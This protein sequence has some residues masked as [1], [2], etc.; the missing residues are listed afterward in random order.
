MRGACHVAVLYAVK[1][2]NTAGRACLKTLVGLKPDKARPRAVTY[3]VRLKPDKARPR[4][5]TCE[6]RLKPDKARPRAI[7]FEVRLKP[8]N[9]RP[10]VI[11][12][13]VTGHAQHIERYFRIELALMLT[14][15]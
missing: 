13:E 15:S 11:A 1:P 3:E 8:D 12:Y 2:R 10:K 6:V 14:C 5:I 7:T 9:A 4:A